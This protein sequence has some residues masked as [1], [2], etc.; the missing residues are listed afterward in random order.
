[1]GMKYEATLAALERYDAVDR[2]TADKLR[3]NG[4]R[5]LNLSGFTN[6]RR[7]AA[8]RVRAAFYRDT[9]SFN[10]EE[11]VALMSVERIRRAIGGTPLGKLLGFLP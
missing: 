9:L 8:D 5:S 4:S 2:P 10:T 11:N 7:W 3:H 6:A 1:M